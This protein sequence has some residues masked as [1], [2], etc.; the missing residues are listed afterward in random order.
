MDGIY[1]S[2]ECLVAN[3]IIADGNASMLGGGIFWDGS[4]Q[5]SVVAFNNLWH[6]AGGNYYGLPDLTLQVFGESVHVVDGDLEQ[7][8]SA[9]VGPVP[10]RW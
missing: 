5:Y 6:N 10:V 4:A 7:L 1:G 8:S 9:K 3:N 2:G